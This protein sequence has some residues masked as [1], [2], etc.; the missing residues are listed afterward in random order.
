MLDTRMRKS[1]ILSG[2][3]LAVLTAC[4]VQEPISNIPEKESL[5]VIHEP[6]KV[7][8]EFED[9]LLS[10]IEEDL[11]AGSVET[12]SESL[13]AVLQELGVK[14]LKRVFPDAGEFEPRTRR[15][16]L[17]RYYRAEFTGQQ[18]LTKAAAELSSLPG[19]VSARPVR[20]VRMNAFNDPYLNHQWHLDN[21]RNNGIDINIQKVWDHFTT[22][23]RDVIVS[24]VDEGVWSAHPDLAANLWNDGS[25]H[26]G[27]NFVNYSPYVSTGSGHGTHVAGII[28]AVNNNGIG[29]AGVAG[30]DAA[31]GI[32]GVRIMS[33][34]VF[35]TSE[36]ADDD[37][38]VAAIK[39]GAD[40]GAVISNNSWGYYADGILD[41]NEDGTVSGE[42][43]ARYKSLSI[44]PM[45]RSAIDYFIK[46]A[47]C[48]NDGN[49]LPDSPMKGGLVLFASGN[50]NIDYDILSAYE[51]VISVGAYGYNGSKA[52]YSNYGAY[53]DVAAPGGDG[54][55]STTSV[56]STVPTSVN[57]S[58]Y[59]GAGWSGTSM[60]TPHVSGVAAL[61][62]SYFGGPGFTQQTCKKILLGG[63]GKDVGGK[64]TP[65]GKKLD[66]WSVFQYGLSVM[67]GDDPSMRQAPVL[68]LSQTEIG[69]RAHQTLTIIVSAYDPDGDAVTITCDP[70]SDALVFDQA[71]GR[72]VITG[73]N[74]PSGIYKAV[75]T[76]TDASGL[77]SQVTLAYQIHPNNAPIV[78][79]NQPDVL[80]YQTNEGR[81]IDLSQL[82]MDVDGEEPVITV[83][84]GGAS[85]LSAD[86]ISGSLLRIVS[87]GY[88]CATLTLTAT[89]ALGASASTSFQVA[90]KVAKGKA[91]VYPVP[92]QDEVFFWVDS[93]EM[94]PL[95]VALYSAYGDDVL[96]AVL[97]GSV[98]QPAS[99]DISDLAPGKYVAILKYGD[100]SEKV[101]VVK[102]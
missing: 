66:A 10:L 61:L 37:M 91:D 97:Q 14:S 87:G 59:E 30:G 44:D 11:A 77:S 48:D 1:T 36:A 101:Q 63:L 67:S 42:E 13:N 71:G 3:L 96:T 93:L 100:V 18:P 51:P 2:L 17:H 8:L 23:R 65:I 83:D 54:Y 26:I 94:I 68:T 25:G 5:Q 32:P 7:V 24:V 70:G 79:G 19:V 29:V 16:G 57:S 6:G 81:N 20:K 31:A 56:W 90:V 84:T 60:A 35:A 75:F 99:L 33:C 98:F 9:D 53:V 43:L 74:A 40:H 78:Q 69:V 27:Y 47:G 21:G 73:R 52:S 46:Y 28:G 12:K 45:Y 80:F 58:G 55:S 34:Q 62:V 89:D 39:W 4:Q 49:Q 85:F 22:G 82:F 92:A 76:A 72:A 41:D 15:E 102:I 50:E 86:I 95:T 38:T 88:G 64:S